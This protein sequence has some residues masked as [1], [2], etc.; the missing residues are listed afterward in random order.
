MTPEK[1]V[2]LFLR[3]VGECARRDPTA[4]VLPPE[5]EIVC[6]GAA[7]NRTLERK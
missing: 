2:E 4:P 7:R 6:Q 3:S 1:A 5:A